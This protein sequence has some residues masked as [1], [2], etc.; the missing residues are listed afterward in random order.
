MITRKIK[1]KRNDE[2][3]SREQKHGW[4]QTREMSKKINEEVNTYKENHLSG[5]NS[6]PC[7]QKMLEIR[8]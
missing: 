1:K 4:R 8:H 7:I 2:D 5:L 6:I 3:A